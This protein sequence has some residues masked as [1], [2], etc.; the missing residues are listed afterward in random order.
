MTLRKL[1][2]LIFS[3]NLNGFPVVE[4]GRL[5]GIVTF[6]D[7]RKMPIADQ[8]KTLV[9]DVAVKEVVAVR[10]DQSSKYAMDLMYLNKIGRLPVVSGDDPKKL[11]GIIT[12]T[13]VIRA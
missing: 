13:D 7:L 4:D 12:R 9:G 1:R 6:D 11:L 2:E 10:P 5:A 8:D 3:S